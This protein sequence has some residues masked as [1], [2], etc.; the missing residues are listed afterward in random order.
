M[1][2]TLKHV[3]LLAGVSLTTVSHVVNGT[4]AVSAAVRARVEEAIRLTG[5][6]PNSV[7][8]SLKLASTRTIGLAIQ[9]IRNPYFTDVV[10]AL[11]AKARE[12]GFTILLS[13]FADD[14]EREREALRVLVERRV[15]GLVIAPGGNGRTAL[16]WLSVRKVPV[17]QIDRIADPAFDSVVASNTSATRD[18]VRHLCAI[19]HRRVAMLAGLAQLS[20][21]RERLAGYRRGLLD[22]GLQPDPAL[23]ADGG[24]RSQPACQATHALLQR[25]D[26]PTAIVAGNNLMALGA[27]R[28]LHE[29][30]LGVPDDVAL[31]AYDDFEWADLFHPRLT[32]VAQPCVEIGEH[33]IKLLLDRI[34]APDLPPR[35]V[36]LPAVMRHRDSCGCRL[37]GTTLP[38][39]LQCA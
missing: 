16:E 30:G 8:R 14:P 11:E 35:H 6:T 18:M 5:Y 12:R 38:P 9:D 37:N 10:H 23:T 22:A 2:A 20:S 4:R 21:T 36:R 28:A 15:D 19:G 25:D 33:A 32:T 29:R 39:T 7:A 3:S 34:H 31:V 1:A 24:S 26:P 17:V 27:M 13:D